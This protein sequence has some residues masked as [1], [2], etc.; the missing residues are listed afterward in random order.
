M[1]KLVESLQLQYYDSKKEK[2]TEEISVKKLFKCKFKSQ[3]KVYNF[4]NSA[5]R[6]IF[7]QRF[8]A[9]GKYLLKFF[10]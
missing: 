8:K 9:F 2:K 5:S 6:K 10:N 1:H 3:A 7:T 4:S